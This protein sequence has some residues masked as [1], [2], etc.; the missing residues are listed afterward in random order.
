[1][2]TKTRFFSLCC[3]L[4]T[5][6]AFSSELFAQSATGGMQGVIR[7]N[8]SEEGLPGVTI[9]ATNVDS[10]NAYSA[11]S[12]ANGFYQITNV[13]PGNYAVDFYYLNT[14]IRRTNIIVALGKITPVHVRI[15][16]DSTGT[17]EIIEITEKAPTIDVGS[18][19]QGVSVDKNYL[20]NIPVP[21]RTFESALGAAPGSQGDGLGV[22]FSGST[23]LENT[24]VIE[25]V[26]TTGLNF[27]NVGTSLINDFLEE[28]EVITGGYNAEFGRSTGG[29]VNVAIRS[30]TNTFEG[31][32]FSHY[33]ADFLSVDSRDI[34]VEGSSIE[35]D[36]N[37]AYSSDIGFTLGG[38]IVRDKA[39][40]F[41]GFTPRF[42]K[43][44]VERITQRRVDENQ[45]S[46]YDEDDNGFYIYEEIE[47]DDN[48]SQAG[49]S[50][51]FVSKINGAISP[52]HQGQISLTGTPS[53]SE[54]LI[55]RAEPKLR[56]L[57]YSSDTYDLATKW[58]S[59]FND[60]KTEVE[61]V[62][63]YH[64][65][66]YQSTARNSELNDVP[67]QRFV[68]GD[69]ATW[70]RGD[71]SGQF[72]SD[73]TLKKC[74]D[75][76]LADGDDFPL[77][78]NCPDDGYG[79]L[80]GGPGGLSDDKETRISGR[81]HLSQRINFLGQHVFKAGGD[82]ELNETSLPRHL[83]GGAVYN[84]TLSGSGQVPRVE[85]SRYVKLLAN[86]ESDSEICGY[87]T[88]P[89]TEEVDLDAPIPCQFIDEAQPVTGSTFNW[90][91]FLQ[92]SWSILPNLTVNAGL[93]YEQQKLRFSQELQH[94]VDPI[95]RNYLGENAMVLDDLI[96]PRLGVIYDWTKE[97]RSKIYGHWGRFFQSIPLRINERSFGGESSYRQTYGIDQCGDV[98]DPFG[99]P[100]GRNCATVDS[101]GNAVIPTY[102]DRL[103]GSGVLIAPGIRAQFL[104]ESVLGVEYELFEDLRLGFSYKNRRMGRV[105]EDVST[106]GANH[107]VI[108]N[109]GEWDEEEEDR[110]VDNIDALSEDT[111]NGLSSSEVED[112]YE[113]VFDQEIGI[114]AAGFVD[115]N[116]GVE[117]ISDEEKID[118][119]IAKRSRLEEELSLYRGIRT[120]DKARRDYDAFEFTVNKR[121][122]G[123]YFIQAA[124][125]YSITE[126]NYPG[127]FSRDTGQVDPNIT[128]QFDLIELLANRD[129]PLP[130]DRP[131]YIKFDGYRVWDFDDIG[132]FTAGVRFRA[133]SGIN[134]SVLGAHWL[135]GRNESYLLQRGSNGRNDFSYDADL[136][137]IYETKK[138]VGGMRASIFVDVFSIFNRQ[139]TASTD[140]EYTVDSAN[141]VVGGSSED[142]VFLKG[143][144]SASGIETGI[145]V[146]RK[147]NF[148]N[149][150][151]YY[152]PLFVRIGARVNF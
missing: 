105:L 42:S 132:R 94:T 68:F 82:V 1:M 71:S 48:Y 133:L 54:G 64:Y 114:E 129:G 57:D 102:G 50:Y 149:T 14:T 67:L 77:I 110:I 92:D 136:K 78:S 19:K 36:A 44:N 111:L 140:Q 27:G 12:A 41:V 104:D 63:G 65:R 11:I 106:D 17:G 112:L 73:K 3:I 91:A 22:S 152:S 7:D 134:K 121:F 55:V 49:Q 146:T 108:A 103:I 31:S 4:L 16:S 107:Y 145:P 34:D 131:H 147:L 135:Y 116:G 39:W 95:T 15:D 99:G 120:F 117:L 97:G 150:S 53:R 90:S 126:G 30:G 142:L 58:N 23:S 43:T 20:K 123:K 62:V 109:P 119:L 84:T 6:I 85:V 75:G 83:S 100:D 125:T 89:I 72:E 10:G 60:N 5:S 70:G 52:E 9:I 37:L 24:Y 46:L 25:G 87:Q 66:R 81:V 80:F 130:Q 98:T 151:S 40:F 139:T 32:V 69:L 88:N 38:P 13:I 18:T 86:A 148:D 115:A 143:T 122:S 56:Y 8:T 35:V 28:I 93:R 113:T 61:G 51:Q 128:S 45:D 33:S 79:Y 47:R 144:H 118:Q 26:N 141:P 96:A 101:N 74:F 137:F 76:G 59:K 127:L 2:T 21:G 138:L 124:Y 29:V